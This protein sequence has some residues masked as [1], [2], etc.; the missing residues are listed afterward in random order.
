MNRTIL[1]VGDW[2]RHADSNIH[3]AGRVVGLRDEAY[4]VVEWQRGLLS[5]HRPRS[6]ELVMRRPDSM[7]RDNT[8]TLIQAT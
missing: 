4:V 7:L 3:V 8:A 1:E 6:L 2:V 5:T